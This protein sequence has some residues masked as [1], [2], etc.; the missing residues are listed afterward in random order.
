MNFKNYNIKSVLYINE[1]EVIA[2]L[3]ITNI[4]ILTMA[5]QEW[6]YRNCSLGLEIFPK[7][8]L[9]RYSSYALF[10]LISL[11]YLYSEHKFTYLQFLIT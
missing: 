9:S 10:S 8:K 2:N 3:V 1:N 4:Y 5:M 7:S 6:L 11:Q